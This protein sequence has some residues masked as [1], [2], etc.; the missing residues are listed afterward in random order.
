MSDRWEKWPA[1]FSSWSNEQWS[2]WHAVSGAS[3][4]GAASSA[5]PAPPPPPPPQAAD[6]DKE[7]E[8]EEDEAEQTHGQ[9]QGGKSKRKR[10]KR[11]GPKTRGAGQRDREWFR[12]KADHQRRVK[13]EAQLEEMIERESL[14]VGET[15]A[16]EVLLTEKERQLQ[17]ATAT[18]AEL[19]AKC[20]LDVAL[21]R[22]EQVRVLWSQS[23]EKA[24]N[25]NL[26]LQA[27]QKAN[28]E[29]LTDVTAAR[30][31]LEK[32]QNDFQDYKADKEMKIQRLENQ[33]FLERVE[34]NRLEEE[35][36]QAKKDLTMGKAGF[37]T[38]VASKE[39]TIASLKKEKDA[40]A[41]LVSEF[42]RQFSKASAKS[43]GK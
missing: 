24:Y 10:A 23:E 19:R 26:Q 33:I 20:S 37:I 8:E 40:L 29:R 41:D 22:K 15:W 18:S 31:S 38:Q 7:E 11:N 13:A 6:D 3:G 28:S 9:G 5:V 30:A 42:E 16:A 32:A 12:Q 14:M 34:K 1:G 27:V 35:L 2:S 36:A 4:S 17:L 39:K 21:A 43:Q 25:L